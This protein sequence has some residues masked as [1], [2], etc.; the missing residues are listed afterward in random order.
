M[1]FSDK[2]RNGK[3]E[4]SCFGLCSESVACSVHVFVCGYACEALLG[5]ENDLGTVS[6]AVEPD[7]FIKLGITWD[8]GRVGRRTHPCGS[9]HACCSDTCHQGA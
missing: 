3:S 4:V 6:T 2:Q 5:G 7:N 9:W 8:D 1:S